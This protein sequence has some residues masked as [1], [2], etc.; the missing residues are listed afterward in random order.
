M[1]ATDDRIRKILETKAQEAKHEKEA[2][3]QLKQHAETDRSRKKWAE[4]THII[5]DILKDFEQKMAAMKLQ[6]RFQDV[7]QQG[8]TIA[9]GRIFGRVSGRELQ[10]TLNV[11]PSGEIHVFRG[12]PTVGA[13]QVQSTSPVAFS[14]LTAN[15]AQYESLILDAIEA[16]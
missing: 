6:L 2:E 7:G 4:D 15:R 13:H 14:V 9:V 3:D 11:Q 1:S 10:L 16:T 5:A 12:G 8:T